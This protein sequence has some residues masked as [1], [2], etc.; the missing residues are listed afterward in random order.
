MKYATKKTCG[1][2]TLRLI[3]DEERAIQADQA[4]NTGF[5]Y[6]DRVQ[7]CRVVGGGF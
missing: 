2:H 3:E 6:S 5:E 7:A 4:V 1:R